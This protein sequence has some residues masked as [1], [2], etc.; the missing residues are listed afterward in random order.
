MSTTPVEQIERPVVIT[1]MEEPGIFAGAIM[2]GSQ[3]I[4]HDGFDVETFEQAAE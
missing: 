1:E 3:A 4:A 2:D